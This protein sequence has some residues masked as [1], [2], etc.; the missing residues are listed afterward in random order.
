MIDG[1]DKDTPVTR[2][3]RA[4]QVLDSLKN[5]MAA[6]KDLPRL[7]EQFN[8]LSKAAAKCK[9]ADKEKLRGHLAKARESLTTIHS[10]NVLPKMLK[11]IAKLKAEFAK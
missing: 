6:L 2:S 9:A 1:A 4:N 7:A 5:K 10:D 11:S 3:A 8:S